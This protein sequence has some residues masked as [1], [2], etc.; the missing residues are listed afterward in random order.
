MTSLDLKS[1]DDDK[2]SDDDL[3]RHRVGG[4]LVT[5]REIARSK[6]CMSPQQLLAGLVWDDDAIIYSYQPTC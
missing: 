6:K 2:L 1:L 4:R 5:R 3:K